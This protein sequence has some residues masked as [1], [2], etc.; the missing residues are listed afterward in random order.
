MLEAGQI[1][2]S[3]KGRDKDSLLVVTKI[4]NG[5]YWVADGGERPLGRPKRKNPKHLRVT[6]W[7]LELEQ[8]ITDKQLRRQLRDLTGE[9][10]RKPD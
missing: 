7:T 4:E 6:R 1:V 8:A 5:L 9:M 3:L 10:D 2:L